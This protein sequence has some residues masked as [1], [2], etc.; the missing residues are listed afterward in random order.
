MKN[1]YISRLITEFSL[2]Y[3]DL[4]GKEILQYKILQYKSDKEKDVYTFNV[5]TAPD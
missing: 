2:M 4:L 5:F 3:T 1:K